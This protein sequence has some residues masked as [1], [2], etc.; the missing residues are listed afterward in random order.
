MLGLVLAVI[1]FNFLTIPT[2]KRLVRSAPCNDHHHLLITLIAS[3]CTQYQC[4]A[5]WLRHLPMRIF[6]AIWD[7]LCVPV[8][9]VQLFFYNIFSFGR[10]GEL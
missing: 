2:I 5:E 3:R 7:A 6:R 8:R 4:V 1:F 9:H 10:N